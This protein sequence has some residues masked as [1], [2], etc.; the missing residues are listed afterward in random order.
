MAKPDFH[1]YLITDRNLVAD[2]ASAVEEALKGGVQAVQLREKDLPLR[3]LLS[4]AA[5]MRTLTRRYGALLFI[6]DRVDVAMAI[7]ADG[8]HLAQSSLPAD[9]VRRISQGR[10]LIG[11][12]THSLDEA[13]DAQAKKAD[14]VT[15][16]PVFDTPSKMQ[17]GPPL[18]LDALEEVREYL[19]IPLF[20]I[21]GIKKHHIKDVLR[22]KAN[23]IAVISGILSADDI[24]NETKQ[25]RELTA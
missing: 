15:F 16:G 20:A 21:G 3:D 12:S 17:Y 18:G 6:N 19:D 7:E 24:L 1:L 23:G 4:L 2:L 5:Q 9:A 22:T 11:V 13:L 10:L 25:Y 14:F 8:V